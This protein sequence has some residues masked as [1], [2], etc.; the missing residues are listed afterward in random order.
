MANTEAFYRFHRFNEAFDRDLK[1]TA[2]ALEGLR[3]GIFPKVDGRTEL[4]VGG[5]P[6]RKST[7]FEDPVARASSAIRQTATMG[8]VRA[9][10]AL[11]DFLTTLEADYA[12][13][14]FLRAGYGPPAPKVIAPE[15][16]DLDIP[17][18]CVRLGVDPS[19][20]GFAMPLHDYFNAARNCIVHRNGRASSYLVKAAKSAELRHCLAA[21][22]TKRGARLPELPAIN[23]GEETDWLP[24]HAILCVSVYY[25]VATALNDQMIGMLGRDGVVYL[26]AHYALIDDDPIDTGARQSA[27]SVVLTLLQGRYRYREVTAAEIVEILRTAERWKYCLEK[28]EQLSGTWQSERN[29]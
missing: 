22:P 3:K 11:E 13:T 9:T 29:K 23:E 6:W 28:F 2:G 27:Q 24:R 12:R 19:I 1:V 16:K 7:S 18:A 25:A 5:E 26:A 14:A 10:A 4:P 15:W 21:W 8:I 17:K 20:V